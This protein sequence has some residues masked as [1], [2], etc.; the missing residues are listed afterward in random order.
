MDNLKSSFNTVIRQKIC[1]L[2]T[3]SK[4]IEQN[5][6]KKRRKEEI[7]IKKWSQDFYCLG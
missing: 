6:I 4:V 5:E 3:I 1:P 2:P 7:E